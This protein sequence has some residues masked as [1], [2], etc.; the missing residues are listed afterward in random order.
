MGESGEARTDF[1][2]IWDEFF[3]GHS[4]VYASLDPTHQEYWWDLFGYWDDI[5][6]AMHLD[7]ERGVK[8]R[9]ER[10]EMLC[11]N[12]EKIRSGFSKSRKQSDLPESLVALQHLTVQHLEL[13][14]LELSI[15]L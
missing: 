13:L 3:A 7:V 12:I 10:F 6:P 9:R 8:V 15:S 1:D 2:E 5:I 4:G 14:K 11:S